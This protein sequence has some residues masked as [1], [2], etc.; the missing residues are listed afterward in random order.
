MCAIGVESTVTLSI[1]GKRVDDD[2]AGGAGMGLQM[3]IAGD[4]ILPQLM[5]LNQRSH[6]GG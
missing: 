2:L 3:E 6:V 5:G 1:R 4:R